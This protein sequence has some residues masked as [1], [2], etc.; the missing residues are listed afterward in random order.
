MAVSKEVQHFIEDNIDLMEQDTTQSW[1]QFFSNL[2]SIND[3]KFLLELYA[4]L[5]E[6]TL[7]LD[8]ISKIDFI[9]RAW[10]MDCKDTSPYV[11]PSHIKHV[12]ESA[13]QNAAFSEIHISNNV[14]E[15]KDYAFYGLHSCKCMDLSQLNTSIKKLDAKIFDALGYNAKCT[16]ILPK[17]IEH[18]NFGS[19][20]GSSYS[21][22]YLDR[23]EFRGTIDDWCKIKISGYCSDISL[24]RHDTK[25]YI[26]GAFVKDIVVNSNVNDLNF[27]GYQYLESVVLG[28]GCLKVSYYAFSKCP[29]LHTVRLSGPVDIAP[30]AFVYSDNV[31]ID[32]ILPEDMQGECLGVLPFDS[33][34]MVERDGMQFISTPS[35]EIAYLY[36]VT[37]DTH[38]EIQVPEGCQK[39][40]QNAFIQGLDTV[41]LPTTLIGMEFQDNMPKALYLNSNI[42]ITSRHHTE[43]GG[44]IA[45]ISLN[46]DDLHTGE[47][48]VYGGVLKCN[49]LFTSK[50]LD[51]L[52]T[53]KHDLRFQHVYDTNGKA[54]T[55]IHLTTDP[56][57]NEFCALNKSVITNVYIDNNVNTSISKQG[58]ANCPRLR[59]V[60]LGTGV[61]KL[62]GSI[63]ANSP[64]VTQ[65]KYLGTVR[66]WKSIKKAS[67]WR[68]NSNLQYIVCTDGVIEL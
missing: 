52:L 56:Y 54:L 62:Y 21:Y 32:P 34:S 15:I 12:E 23:I 13:F 24:F 46:V 50:S 39:V 31:K 4:L 2:D 27:S 10:F 33:T 58:L 19:G 28:Q 60:T 66:Q 65:I 49:N 35:N 1:Q 40:L 16:L 57:Y 67:L 47:Y 44:L 45:Y 3:K 42:S 68:K 18:I 7:Q 25:L 61:T 63:L 5:R 36:R 8:I 14:T 41:H 6:P 55:K 59:A 30:T 37:D 22:W 20:W 43:C 26:D 48:S 17:H 9:P 11:I 64:L 29:K 51:F 38:K 53:H